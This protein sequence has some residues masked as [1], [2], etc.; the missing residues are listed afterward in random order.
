MSVIVVIIDKCGMHACTHTNSRNG[1]TMCAH[2]HTHIT[3]AA[4]PHGTV[5]PI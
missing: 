3:M 2:T 5:K 4:Q 1:K